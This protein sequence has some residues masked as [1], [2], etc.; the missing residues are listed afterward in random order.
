[1]PFKCVLEHELE[2]LLRVFLEIKMIFDRVEVAK[3]LACIDEIPERSSA[4]GRV[5]YKDGINKS[6]RQ[7]WALLRERLEQKAPSGSL[8]KRF[9]AFNTAFDRVGRVECPGQKLEPMF[10]LG[11]V[12]IAKLVE[13]VIQRLLS[14]G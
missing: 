8:D 9:E 12:E 7:I 3:E 5:G 4:V 13:N 6:M 11:H 10:D 2:A 1:M 14:F